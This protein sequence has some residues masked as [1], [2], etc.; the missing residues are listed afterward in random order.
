MGELRQRLKFGKWRDVYGNS[1]EYLGRTLKQLPNF[2]IQVSMKQ[3]IGEKLRPVTLS[4]E[5]AREKTSPL[6]EQEATWLAELVDRC[7]GVEKKDDQML[8]QLAM[9]QCHG[10]LAGRPTTTFTWPIRR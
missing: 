9:W 1:A 6:M 3:Y 10:A 8:V 5:R 2:E 4:K 7:Y